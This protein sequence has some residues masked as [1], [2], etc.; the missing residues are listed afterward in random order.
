MHGH[1]SMLFR[2]VMIKTHV[3]QAAINASIL[4]TATDAVVLYEKYMTLTY[5]TKAQPLASALP[6]SV[7]KTA[8]QA[9]IDAVISK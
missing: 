6:D 8:L 2:Q 9:R 5:K 1:W 7:D 4:K 3:V